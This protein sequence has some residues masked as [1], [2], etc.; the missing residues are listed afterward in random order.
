MP[1]EEF[2]GNVAVGGSK[3]PPT[4]I[5]RI[6]DKAL[7]GCK[8]LAVHV[9]GEQPATAS[10][11]LIVPGKAANRSKQCLDYRDKADSHKL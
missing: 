11:P 1:K 3:T 6:A 8:R 10:E 2:V 7:L 9:D 4:N 5:Q